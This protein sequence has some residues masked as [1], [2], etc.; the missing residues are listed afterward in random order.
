MMTLFT[1][2]KCAPGPWAFVTTPPLKLVV[3]LG[4]VAVIMCPPPSTVM[5]LGTVMGSVTGPQSAV[6]VYVWLPM[7]PLTV[8]AGHAV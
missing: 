2:I 4:S 5:P 3:A 8:P 6:N 7:G 1:C